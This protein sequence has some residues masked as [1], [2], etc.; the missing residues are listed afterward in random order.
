MPKLYDTIQAFE[1]LPVPAECFPDQTFDTISP[2][3]FPFNPFC[4]NQTDTRI[5]KVNRLYIQSQRETFKHDP[6]SQRS[7]KLISLSQSALL[8]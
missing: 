2:D 4:Y 6:I 5:V 3:R 7:A 1:H 8:G